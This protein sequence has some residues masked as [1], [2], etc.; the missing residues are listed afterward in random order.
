MKKDCV[1][2]GWVSYVIG[3]PEDDDVPGAGLNPLPSA[4]RAATPRANA[5]QAIST[6]ELEGTA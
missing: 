6:C 4:W 2:P 3:Q 5:E 1:M